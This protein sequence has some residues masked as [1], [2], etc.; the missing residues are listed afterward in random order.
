MQEVKRLR[1]TASDVCSQNTELNK[2]AV[3][4]EARVDEQA[5]TIQLLQQQLQF[6]VRKGLLGPTCKPAHPSFPS[7]AS[8]SHAALTLA[9][10][11]AGNEHQPS[12]IGHQRW[13][14]ARLA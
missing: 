2:R 8:T 1:K 12:P 10:I 9:L 14:L 11:S 6:L 7:C 3:Q 4:A 13:Q 5:Q